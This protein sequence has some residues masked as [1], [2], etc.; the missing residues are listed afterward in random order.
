MKFGI[1][2]SPFHSTQPEEGNFIPYMG[3]LIRH[4]YQQEYEHKLQINDVIVSTALRGLG[5]GNGEPPG[6]PPGDDG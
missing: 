1:L 4:L 6:E 2:F 3:L 5:G